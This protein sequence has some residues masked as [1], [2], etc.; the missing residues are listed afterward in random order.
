MFDDIKNQKGLISLVKNN[1]E[2]ITSL[3]STHEIKEINYN[4]DALF[5]IIKAFL[6]LNAEN[7]IKYTSISGT[8]QKENWFNNIDKENFVKALDKN[9]VVT[10]CNDK[11]DDIYVVK[12]TNKL[13]FV[14]KSLESLKI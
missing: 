8:E 5:S 6:D 1:K 7:Y 10:L 9:K 4:Q 13:V 3:L 12:A 2:V 11:K 14:A